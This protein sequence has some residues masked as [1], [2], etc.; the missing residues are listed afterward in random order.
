MRHKTLTNTAALLA[1][2]AT[3]TGCT[4]MADYLNR[5]QPA[6]AGNTPQ[7]LALTVQAATTQPVAIDVADALP[8]GR[9]ALTAV[10]ALAG[11]AAAAAGTFSASRAKAADLQTKLAPLAHT[12]TIQAAPPGALAV[13]TK[14]TNGTSTTTNTT[15]GA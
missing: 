11:L 3:I 6:A 12:L 8:W 14:S 10:A 7:Q 9:T 13:A 1:A 4:A 2:A 5:R 15:P